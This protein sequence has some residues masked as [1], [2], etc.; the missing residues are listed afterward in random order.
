MLEIAFR[1]IPTIAFFWA[2]YAAYYADIPDW[3]LYLGLAFVFAQW[4]NS[5]IEHDRDKALERRLDKQQNSIDEANMR[6]SA[7]EDIVR[8]IKFRS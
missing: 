2:C 4:G 6:L 5:W 3:A 7:I 8:E 1:I